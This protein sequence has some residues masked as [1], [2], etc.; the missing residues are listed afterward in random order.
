M[1]HSGK[2]SS[3]RVLMMVAHL[4]L[5]EG[6]GGQVRQARNEDERSGGSGRQEREWE[7][8]V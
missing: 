4:M 2:I 3:S 5:Q 8:Y 1:E 7:A 6:K